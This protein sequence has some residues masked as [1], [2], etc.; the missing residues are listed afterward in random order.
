MGDTTVEECLRVEQP[1]ETA[2][3]V[4]P[5]AVERTM[6]REEEAK[7]TIVTAE[8]KGGA[9]PASKEEV[10]ATILLRD[11]ITNWTDVGGVSPTHR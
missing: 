5:A 11:G 4:A 10:L 6:G 7:G 3:A 1:E 2:E 9:A 8:E